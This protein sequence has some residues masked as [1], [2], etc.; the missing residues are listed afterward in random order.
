[1]GSRSEQA[2]STRMTIALVSEHAGPPAAPGAL[3]AGSQNLYVAG[4]AT[5]LSAL[6][7]R[8]VV[9]TRCDDPQVPRRVRTSDGYTV[10]HVPAGPARKITEDEVLAHLGDF[11]QFLRTDWETQVP[12]VVHAHGWLSGLAAVLSAQ[13]TRIPVLQSY[14]AVGTTSRQ[15][16]R[17]N[18]PVSTKRLAVERLVGHEAARVVAVS[19]D[20]AREVLRMG[21]ERTKLSVVPRGVD[22]DLFT[23]QDS[24]TARTGL[25]Q[26]VS[27]GRLLPHKGFEDTIR[28][29]SKVEDVRL[30][31]AGGAAEGD[32]RGDP[33]ARRLLTQAQA[34]GVS[35]KVR[36]A[37]HVPH[38]DLPVLLRS[39]DVVVC[40]PRHRSS[41]SVAL[42]AMACGVPV[43]A[44]EVGALVDSVIDGLTGVQVPP[45]RPD[46]IARALR[47]LLADGTQRELLGAAGR[48]RVH[49][50]YSWQRIATD[51][52]R[53]YTATISNH[54]A[55]KTSVRLSP[56]LRH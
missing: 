49:A 27:V 5:A 37:G 25:R 10:V 14:H 44:T 17:T 52:V 9:Y 6:G 4:L 30:V 46:A 38:A 56:S 34:L 47:S 22:L 32:V 26:I 19:S 42:E 45:R 7:H 36:F 40:T 50:R 2:T 18:D 29:L 41:G 53:T 13:H 28:A 31:I 39:A 33:E 43:L 35:E 3:D 51:L 21:I 8:V 23:P 16:R 12:D 24:P 55:A 54:P 11:V 48:D 20:E 15:D 1:M